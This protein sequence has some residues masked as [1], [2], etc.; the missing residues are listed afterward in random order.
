MGDART[1]RVSDVL[2]R[3]SKSE[4]MRKI[5]EGIPYR[6]GESIGL[7]ESYAKER[8]RADGNI[9]LWCDEFFEKHYDMKTLQP[10]PAASA[11]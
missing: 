8:G 2:A 1:E 10:K 3:M 6:M 7:S 9:C 11:A 5:N 4:I